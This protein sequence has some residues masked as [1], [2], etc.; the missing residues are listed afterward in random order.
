MKCI[1][2]HTKS[3]HLL[4]RISTGKYDYYSRYMDCGWKVCDCLKFKEQKEV[5]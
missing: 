3:S 2:G 4:R 1:C 5:Q